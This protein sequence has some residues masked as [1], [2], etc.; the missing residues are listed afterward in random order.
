M[1]ISCKLR[2]NS[3]R[4]TVNNYMNVCITALFLRSYNIYNSPNLTSACDFRRCL[5]TWRVEY[6]L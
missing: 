2:E 1:L 4:P 5:Y 6:D 3:Q